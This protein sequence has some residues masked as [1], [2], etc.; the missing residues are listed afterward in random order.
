MVGEVPVCVEGL[1]GGP[2]GVAVGERCS[3][4]EVRKTDAN[5]EELP[6][7]ALS[8]AVVVAADAAAE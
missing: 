4:L 3:G 7:E 6:E 5:P 8:S 1:L 2:L